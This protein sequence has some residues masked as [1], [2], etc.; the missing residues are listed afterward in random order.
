MTFTEGMTLVSKYKCY[1]HCLVWIGESFEEKKLSAQQIGNIMAYGGGWMLRNCYDWDC[2]EDTNFWEIIQDRHHDISELPSKVRNQIR[3]CLK[4]CQI[5]QISNAELVN[6]NG[7]AVYA[8]AYKRYRDVS[9]TVES[10]DLWEHNILSQKGYEYWAVYSKGTGMMIAWASNKVNTRSVE[11]LTLKAIP[12]YMNRHYPYYGL[13]YE[14]GHYYLEEKRY[15]YVTDGWR[16]VTEH[17]NIQPF[18]EQKFLFRKAYCRMRL[19]YAPWFGMAVKILYP[20]RHLK[21]LPLNVRNVLKFEEINREC[22]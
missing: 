12:E 19:Y 5:R 1:K 20:F 17:S 10:R 18:L 4:D 22:F 15:L 8:E 14:M 2:S 11:Y 21:F 7:Y 6:D 3:R 16:S 13:L 9:V